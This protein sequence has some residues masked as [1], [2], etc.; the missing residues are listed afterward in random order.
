[1]S[2]KPLA[3]LSETFCVEELCGLLNQQCLILLGCAE[4]MERAIK[5]HRKMGG[6]I[7]PAVVGQ[8]GIWDPIDRCMR[9]LLSACSLPFGDRKRELGGVYIGR[10]F[11]SC[12][13]ISTTSHTHTYFIRLRYFVYF[14]S[15]D[16]TR[17]NNKNNAS[18]KTL[19]ISVISQWQ[20]QLVMSV[21]R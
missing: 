20:N 17:N 15:L 21:S 13:S 10:A 7:V 3:R 11:P 14:S 19:H 8:M 5:R 16:F 9:R 6:G 4:P 1:M 2:A 12:E 18:F